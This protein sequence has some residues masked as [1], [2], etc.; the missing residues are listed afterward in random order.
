MK[1]KVTQPDGATGK[2]RSD[3][4]PRNGRTTLV[5]LRETYGLSR[6]VLTRALHAS[7][8][9]LAK[10]EKGTSLPAPGSVAKIK[11]L[12]KII[13]GLSRAMKKDFISTWLRSPNDA[14]EGKAPLDLLAEGDYES[15]E[16]LVYFLE[17]GEPV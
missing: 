5:Q 14:C 15:V 12:E 6:Q 8:T 2:D 13:E 9:A 7:N 4:P 1:S 17:A 16:D 11:R 3:H 10:W